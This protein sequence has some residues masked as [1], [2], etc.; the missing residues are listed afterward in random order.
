MKSF[1]FIL[2]L[3]FFI[4]SFLGTNLIAQNQ[5]SLIFNSKELYDK[6]PIKL[7]DN[8]EF[9]WKELIEPGNFKQHTP[10][11]LVNLTSWTNYKDNSNINLP[12]FG[13]ATYRLNFTIA[14]DR[15]HVSIYI[16]RVIASYK[17]WINGKFI[18]ETGKVGKTREETIQRRFTKIIPLDTNET[19][20][21]VVIQVANYYNKIGGITKPILLNE[22]EQLFNK[23]SLQTMV[24]MVYIGSFSFIGVLFLMFYLLYW[25]KDQAVLYF[26]IL[27]I[28]MAYHTLNDR[29][30]PFSVIFDKISWVLLAKTEYIAAYI[31]GLMA[32]LFFALILTDYVHLWYT[33]TVKYIICLFI[34]LLIFLPAP[35]FTELVL[36][37]L[38]SMLINIAYI[39]FITIKAI[40]AKSKVSA[41]LLIFIA[42]TTITFLGHILFF[43]Y[44]NEIALI[45]VKFGYIFVFLFISMIMLQRFSNSFQ[46]LE[47]ANSFA[48]QQ[49]KEISNVNFKLE[50]NLKQL[51]ENN[52]ELDDF[53]H[54]VSHDL[55]TPLVSVYS[56]ASFL[57]ADLKDKLDDNTKNHLI[58]MKDVVTKM[59]SSING[60]LDYSKVS[61]ANKRKEKFYFNDLLEKVIDFVDNQNKSIIHLPEK[62]IEIYANKIELEHV[63]QNLISNSIK[64]NNKDK[65]IIKISVVKHSDEYLFSVKD[66][67]PGIDSKYHSK[68][69]KIFSQLHT[70][71]KD[72]KSTGVGLAIVK[73]IVSKNNGT[74]TVNSEKNKGLEINISWK[75]EI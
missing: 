2:L 53:N 61:K 4:Q 60:L 10:L 26:S 27:C 48:L 31:S 58:M 73:K 75:I 29:Y 55:K 21:E 69:F 56:L 65:T 12:A 70:N 5:D 63:F 25:N 18:I 15:P 11:D 59:E 6:E 71:D 39:I 66:N 72:L 46:E 3:L 14:K 22:S 57:E 62:N 33:K 30:A 23:Q 17:L 74:I 40:L 47:L 32:S 24:D 49:K 54:I 1:R 64:Y 38:F 45:Y 8:W 28:A 7:Q 52:A 41:L 36:P 34:V 44:Q 20:F 19:N 50:E 67:G 35:Y 51:E 9:Y 16:P 13:Y 37:F 42:F 68:I 43:I